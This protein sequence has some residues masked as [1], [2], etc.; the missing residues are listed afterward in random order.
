MF[1]A[2]PESPKAQKPTRR[3]T[4]ETEMTGRGYLTELLQMDLALSTV[5]NDFR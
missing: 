5:P 4:V 3:V 2:V 1:L